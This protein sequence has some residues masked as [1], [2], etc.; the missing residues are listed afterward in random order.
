MARAVLRPES[1]STTESV[2]SLT[3]ATNEGERGLKKI[4]KLYIYINY[5]I[6]IPAKGW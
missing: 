5:K 1:C 6:V 2:L 3:F 4:I